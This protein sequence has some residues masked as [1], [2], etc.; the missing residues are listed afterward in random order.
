VDKPPAVEYIFVEPYADFG[1]PFS[2]YGFSRNP[3]GQYE[4]SSSSS[5]PPPPPSPFTSTPTTHAPTPH[6][7][8]SAAVRYTLPNGEQKL[9]NIV[10]QPHKEMVNFL[11][12]SEY[13]Y[14]TCFDNGAEQ[15]GVYNRYTALFFLRSSPPLIA[16]SWPDLVPRR[17]LSA[18]ER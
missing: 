13:L 7:A 15:G 12:P 14:G 11:D 2:S 1:L 8:L 9:M 10:G 5:S 4:R 18:T 6:Y 16:R 3:Y 17:G